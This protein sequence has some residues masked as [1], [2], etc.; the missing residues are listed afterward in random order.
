MIRYLYVKMTKPNA[1]CMNVYS[2]TVAR[3]SSQ[4]S[5]LGSAGFTDVFM[6]SPYI[7]LIQQGKGNCRITV[8]LEH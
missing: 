7:P 1:I 4:M 2:S 3:S 6:S 5:R 8:M